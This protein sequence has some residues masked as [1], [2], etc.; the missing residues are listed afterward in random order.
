M[1]DLESDGEPID[2]Y[3]ICDLM[4]IRPSKLDEILGNSML[5]G[6]IDMDEEGYIYTT[7]LGIKSLYFDKKV[8][9]SEKKFKSFLKCL[10][11]E[12]LKDFMNLCDDFVDGIDS[13]ED[14]KSLEDIDVEIYEEEE[15][16]T[17][18][19]TVE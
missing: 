14:L 5:E 10:S 19:E 6:I 15:K 16:E 8:K 17:P 13:V 7:D 3:A 18:P 11:T 1:E 9:K 4:D 2:F 12:E